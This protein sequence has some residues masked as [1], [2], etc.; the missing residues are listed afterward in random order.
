MY[1]FPEGG[2]KLLGRILVSA[3]TF[4]KGQESDTLEIQTDAAPVVWAVEGD[5]CS[6]SAF[7]DVKLD[8]VLGKKIAKVEEVESMVDPIFAPENLRRFVEKPWS[9]E[10]WKLPEGAEEAPQESEQIYG[11]RITAEDGS[12]GFVIHRNWSNGYYGGSLSEQP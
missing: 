3:P 7:T 8:A 12:V 11:V 4:G 9:D 5:C 1:G 2:S 10:N 6:H